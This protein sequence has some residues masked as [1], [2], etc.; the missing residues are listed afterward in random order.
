MSTVFAVA[1]VLH[2]LQALKETV[3]PN[4]WSETPLPVLAAPG[5]WLNQVAQ[6]LGQPAG[7]EPAEIHGCSVVRAD[8]ISEPFLIDHD[9]KV[10][11]VLPQWLRAKSSAA[12]SEGGEV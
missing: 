11:P 7:I 8:D 2:S 10:Y 4:E 6:D 3:P 5:W 9:G 12:D 1:N